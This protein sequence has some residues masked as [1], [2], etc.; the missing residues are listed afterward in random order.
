MK[1]TTKLIYIADMQLKLSVSYHI[2]YKP[3][4]TRNMIE[5]IL[6]S[7]KL[8]MQVCCAHGWESVCHL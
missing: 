4:Q 2:F 6:V 5:R 3:K 1:W 7:V 8:Q